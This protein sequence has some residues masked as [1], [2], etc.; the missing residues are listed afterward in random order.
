M[1][2]DNL[3]FFHKWKNYEMILAEHDIYVYKRSKTEKHQFEGHPRIK[4]VDAPLL[5]ISA[6]FIRNAIKEGKS[7]QYLVP[8]EVFEYL[9]SSHLYR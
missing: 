3:S 5:G 9:Q 1:G 7:I 8:Q 4:E 6:T 2:G